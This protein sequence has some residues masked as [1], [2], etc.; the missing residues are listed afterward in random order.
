MLAWPVFV[1]AA[2]GFITC[3]VGWLLGSEVPRFTQKYYLRLL[4]IR[5]WPEFN[6][7]LVGFSETEVKKILLVR[8]YLTAILMVSFPPINLIFFKVG[9]V[10]RRRCIFV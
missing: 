5:G 6:W 9:R 2:L 3:F 4:K 10:Y 1:F 8:T 7:T